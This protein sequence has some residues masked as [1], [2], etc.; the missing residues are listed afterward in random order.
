MKEKVQIKR[1]PHAQDMELPCYMSDMAAGMD[2]AAALSGPV[3]INPGKTVLIPTG[4]AVA[5]PAGYEFQIRPRSGLAIKR[6]LTVVNA[7]GTIDADYRGEIKVGLINLGPEPVTVNPGDRIAQ[8]VLSK[9]WQVE[10]DEVKELDDT[11]RGHG[12][13]GHTGT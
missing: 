13:F 3:T 5:L 4:L 8:M 7:P 12:G 9:V 10:W 2:I 6:G 11:S 1:L